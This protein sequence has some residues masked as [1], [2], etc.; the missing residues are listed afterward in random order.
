MTRCETCVF[1]K[2]RSMTYD[3]SCRQ[4]PPVLV[5]DPEDGTAITRWP[6]TDRDDLCGEW[7][8][9]AEGIV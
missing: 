3:G 8:T 6:V 2:P 9:R 4:R 7:K 5:V 1:W